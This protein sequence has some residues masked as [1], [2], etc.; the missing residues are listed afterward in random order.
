MARKTIRRKSKKT[1]KKRGTMKKRD[2]MKKLPS[3]VE[4][5][6]QKY[7]KTGSL[8]KAHLIFK[9]QALSNARKLFGYNITS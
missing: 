5:A 1:M 7:V 8:K 9:A 2:T 3:P 6:T 4:K